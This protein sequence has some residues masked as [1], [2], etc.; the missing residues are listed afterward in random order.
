MNAHFNI[1]SNGTA[2]DRLRA[3]HAA[4]AAAEQDLDLAS[5]R[6]ARS[7]AMVEEAA[8]AL[9]ACGDVDAAEAA[10]AAAV[11][12][13]HAESGDGAPPVMPPALVERRAALADARSRL[14]AANA[15]HGGLAAERDAAQRALDTANNSVH[16]A[17]K[18]VLIEEADRITAELD[19]TLITAHLRQDQL[20]ALSEFSAMGRGETWLT[21]RLQL[22]ASASARATTPLD[23]RSTLPGGQTHAG[24]QA[25]AVQ[26]LMT[27]LLA[28][29]AE[30]RL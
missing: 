26:R 1:A 23:H 3:G 12:R 24:L 19:A 5:R 10:A 4:R 27:E 15:A 14:A 9:A 11:F 8:R 16:A 6:A 20:L 29:D 13:Q 21:G 2:R 7:Q 25:A 28:G 22:S 30:A 18:A 17:A